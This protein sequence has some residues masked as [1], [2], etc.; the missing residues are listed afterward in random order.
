MNI[1]H[2]KHVWHMD[3]CVDKWNMNLWMNECHTNFTS[4]NKFICQMYSQCMICTNY[5]WT[6]VTQF[7]FLS[8]E[9]LGLWW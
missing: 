6:N 4:S 5:A 1:M 7:P 8:C 3:K 9:M 2:W